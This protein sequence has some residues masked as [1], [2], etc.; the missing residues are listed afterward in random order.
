LF[1]MLDTA[2]KENGLARAPLVP[3]TTSPFLLH[4]ACRVE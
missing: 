3:V 1:K 2:K 4:E